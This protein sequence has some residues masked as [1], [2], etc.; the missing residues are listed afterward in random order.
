MTTFKSIIYILCVCSL[1][2]KAVLQTWRH[3]NPQS[4]A[5]VGP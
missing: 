3:F 4:V 5:V 2:S 1:C